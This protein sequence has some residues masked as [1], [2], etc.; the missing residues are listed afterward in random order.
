M[1]LGYKHSII[2]TL[3]L[4]AQML[5]ACNDNAK[6]TEIA[7]VSDDAVSIGYGGGEELIKFIC[8]DNWTISSDVS[9]ITFGGPTEGSGNAIIKIHIEK[10][11]SGGD[12]TGKLSITCGGNI[13]IIEI[14]QSIKTIDIEHKHPSNLYTKEELLNIKQMV[15]GNSS[16]SITTTYNN[17]MKRCNNALTYTATPYTGQDPTKFIEESYVPGSN[18]RDLAL[19]YWFTGDKKYARKSIEI[20]EAW[21]KAC[22][23]ISYVADAGSAMYLTR[24]M[25]PMVC[26]Y[27][28]LISENIMSDE[29]KK[30]ITDWLQV[31]YREGMISINLWE[32]NDYF[33]KQY[34]QNHLV[35]HSMGILMLGLVTDDDELVQFAIDSPANPRDVKELLSGCIL[36][37]GDTPCSRE[38]AGSAP[39]VKGEIYDRYRHDTGPLKGLQYTHLTLTLLSTTARMCYNNGL[40]LFA[41]TAP[42]GENLRYCF[43]YYSDFY[44]SMDSCIKS[45]YYCGETE[46]MTKAGDNPGM[47][48][49]GLRYYPDSEPI[50]QLINSGTFNRES[51]YMD[52]LGYTRLLSAEINE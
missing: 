22:K 33:N 48:E 51:S 15:E 32:D 30:N 11:T 50:R 27:D 26:A 20:I 28:M 37:D 45:G 40:D 17:L 2:L 52:L 10:N 29:T 25:Y 5:M 43:E 1:K 19:A 41:Y 44:R 35:A 4:L 39:P 42:T 3:L 12:R 31:L 34:Y 14:R 21:A 47:Y 9:W 49:M 13:K 36:M 23:D 8:Y 46:R 18:S 38:K 16:A 6:N 7:L 24:G